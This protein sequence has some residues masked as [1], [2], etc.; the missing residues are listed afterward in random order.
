M[1]ATE[2]LCVKRNSFVL[3][4]TSISLRLIW[5]KGQQNKENHNFKIQFSTIK[6]KPIAKKQ[7][8]EQKKNENRLITSNNYI[9]TSSQQCKNLKNLDI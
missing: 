1:Y 6:N 4:E 8:A 7:T 2:S 9:A 3:P 5:L